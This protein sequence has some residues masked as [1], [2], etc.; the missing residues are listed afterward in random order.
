M[1]I[2]TRA[3]YVDSHGH[4]SWVTLKILLFK[5][6]GN[7]L[8]AEHFPGEVAPRDHTYRGLRIQNTVGE[9]YIY[10]NLGEF[11]SYKC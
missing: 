2:D 10:L 9:H 8:H 4:T 3:S 1:A 6:I 7:K 5:M 11:C